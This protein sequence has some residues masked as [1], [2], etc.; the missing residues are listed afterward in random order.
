MTQRV[1]REGASSTSDDAI[2][3]TQSQWDLGERSIQD[4][5]LSASVGQDLR[6]CLDAVLTPY[7]T[8]ANSLF[9]RIDTAMG[10]QRPAF[11]ALVLFPHELPLANHL[12]KTRLSADLIKGVTYSVQKSN[13]SK[14]I[15]LGLG[16]VLL[17]DPSIAISSDRTD[18]LMEVVRGAVNNLAYDRRWCVL[19]EPPDAVWIAAHAP[20]YS[21]ASGVDWFGYH[22]QE[23]VVWDADLGL[24][25]LSFVYNEA[26]NVDSTW[27]MTKERSFTWW[28]HHFRQIITSSPGLVDND[29]TIFRI[30]AVSDFVVDAK[31]SSHDVLTVLTALAP[32]LSGSSA[33]IYDTRDGSIQLCT[34]CNIHEGNADWLK[35]DF[36]TFAALQIADAEA[37][38]DT[39]A[40]AVRGRADISAHPVNGLRLS[41]DETL[42]IRDVILRTPSGMV[43]NWCIPPVIIAGK[44]LLEDSG[45]KTQWESQGFSALL[46]FTKDLSSILTVSCTPH[47]DLGE[48]CWIKITLPTP[49][50]RAEALSMMNE[51]NLKEYHGASNTSLSGSWTTYCDDNNDYAFMRFLVFLPNRLYN[52]GKLENYLLYM[53]MR[54]RW[55]GVTFGQL[56][57]DIRH[58]RKG[59]P[60]QPM[61]RVKDIKQISERCGVPLLPP[62]HPIYTQ[63]GP[64]IE[65]R[66]SDAYARRKGILASPHDPRK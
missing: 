3:R 40:T 12:I 29:T 18:K 44:D 49:L 56:L 38:A 48:G 4:F 60:P 59:Y 50:S 64:W 33:A 6:D 35:R 54:S 63:E 30:Q 16:G 32:Q 61:L 22:Y 9:S 51:M 15:H 5:S 20:Q 46:P 25:T 55:A 65:G 45:M 52:Q 11:W 31:A 7:R 10:S 57:C 21:R 24:E 43:N 36:S 26:M 13:T 19:A 2:I 23:P 42:A 47:L 58:P 34:T 14:A 37:L 27:S 39:F 62:D 17:Y 41:P 66:L 1:Y 28:P 8:T 53:I